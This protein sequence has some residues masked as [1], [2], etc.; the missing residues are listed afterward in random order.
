MKKIVFLSFMLAS[1]IASVTS[2]QASNI[3]DSTK[4]GTLVLQHARTAASNANN[5]WKGK[6]STNAYVGKSATKTPETLYK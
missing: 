2:A 6:G 3:H 5:S 4:Q 1:V